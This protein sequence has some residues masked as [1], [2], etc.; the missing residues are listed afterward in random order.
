MTGAFY[1]LSMT[2]YSAQSQS[3][4]AATALSLGLQGGSLET[5]A[6]GFMS[7]SSWIIM[8]FVYT[9]SAG[10]NYRRYRKGEIDKGEF[11]HR[12]KINSV[13]SVSSVA[14]GSGGAAAGFAIGTFFMPGVGSVIGA[15]V[16][17]MAGG[18][19]GEKISAK[20]YKHIDK[21]IEEAQEM[22]R[23]I[24]MG[25]MSKGVN[26]T[27]CRITDDRFEEAMQILGIRNPTCIT[28]LYHLEDIEAAYEAHLDV[29]TMDRTH[30][31]REDAEAHLRIVEK[32][33]EFSDAYEDIREYL[34]FYRNKQ[35]KNYE[36]D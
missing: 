2:A 22:R 4:N 20:V 27:L 14:V 33:K 23:N 6:N 34:E 9:A 31:D 35:V 18:F 1:K 25:V 8:A 28:A 13:T 10:L 19:V 3:H 7:K 36:F 21:K 11:W 29:L 30:T 24:E 26:R 12:M 15:V 5:L 17:G 16:G 32:Y